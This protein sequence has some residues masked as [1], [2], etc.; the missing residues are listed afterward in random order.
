MNY[1][2]L[3]IALLSLSALNA[4]AYTTTETQGKTLTMTCEKSIPC[5]LM[6]NCHGNIYVDNQQPHQFQMKNP[7]GSSM[8][9]VLL[10]YA[11]SSYSKAI[12]NPLTINLTI[13]CEYADKW[14][15]FT[16][17]KPTTLKDKCNGFC[18]NP[19]VTMT[20]NKMTF[21]C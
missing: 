13:R 17:S 11:D 7:Q 21:S 14:V 20:F 10:K 2:A 12:T 15:A 18:L 19:H 6:G 5:D 9:P 8:M 3:F 16:V 1:F 4:M